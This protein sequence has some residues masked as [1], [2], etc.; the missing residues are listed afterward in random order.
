VKSAR[1]L[2]L[3]GAAILAIAT[4]AAA[5]TSTLDRCLSRLVGDVAHYVEKKAQCVRS[6]EDQVRK[7]AL[8]SDTRCTTP[9]D[10]G[11]TQI[12]LLKAEERIIGSRASSRRACRDDEIE[13]FYRNTTTCS[14]E[15]ENLDA[16]LLC[17]RRQA[18]NFIDS[19]LDQ[20]YRPF[21][22]PIC[23]DGEIGPSESC[24]PQAFPN[25]CTFNQVCHPDFC[26]CTFRGCGN[27]IIE[28]GEDCDYNTFP[29]GCSFSEF[30][31]SGCSCRPFGS[32]AEAFLGEAPSCL[33]D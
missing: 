30:C 18:S 26:F 10:H 20:I 16:L 3:F 6:C 2:L 4:P 15:N 22:F 13:L 27:G 24:D 25:G 32:A 5:R 7:G 1:S 21:R 23:G 11:P 8:A 9:S 31:D 29:E 28:P 33:T 17:L 12:C 19:M 14:G